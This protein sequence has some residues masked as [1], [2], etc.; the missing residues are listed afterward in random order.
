MKKA[1]VT[2]ANIH[3]VGVKLIIDD[4]YPTNGIRADIIIIDELKNDVA[5]PISSTLNVV[6]AISDFSPLL[7]VRVLTV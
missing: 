6:L 5:V 7:R 1:K 2:I 3:K 4:K